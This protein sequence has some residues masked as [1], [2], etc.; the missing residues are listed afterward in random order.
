MSENLATVDLE[1]A[2]V[3]EQHRYTAE[4]VP[5]DASVAE[6]TRILAL[7]MA[8]PSTDPRGRPQTYGLL[9]ERTGR[10]LNATQTLA[11]AGVEARDK[12]ILTPAIEAGLNH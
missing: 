11:E 3:S 12:V 5:L 4:A 7:D 2:D 10:A 6:L 1:V 8:L 9:H